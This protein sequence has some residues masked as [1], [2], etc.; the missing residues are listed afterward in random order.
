MNV[1]FF[2]WFAALTSCIKNEVGVNYR[3]VK[4]LTILSMNEQFQKNI[5]KQL[6]PNLAKA[7]IEEFRDLTLIDQ[8]EVPLYNNGGD[9]SGVPKV[10][11]TMD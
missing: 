5:I 4:T 7:T 8:L 11:L 2:F 3:N 10:I 6:I 1:V 9:P